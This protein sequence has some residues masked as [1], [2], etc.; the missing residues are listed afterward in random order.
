MTPG[1]AGGINNHLQIMEEFM[2]RRKKI[3]LTG[4]FSILLVFTIMLAGCPDGPGDEKVVQRTGI[5]LFTEHP[6]SIDY[7]DENIRPLKVTA[8]VLDKPDM[9]E[10]GN[11]IE[12]DLDYQW[13]IVNEFTN[14]GGT[15]IEG[16]TERT[17]IPQL[18]QLNNN[19]GFFYVRVSN[20]ATTGAIRFS[21]PARIR[22]NQTLTTPSATMVISNTERQY[23]RGFG[24]MSNAF[25]IGGDTGDVPRYME[26]E[27]IHTMFNPEHPDYMGFKVLR[28]CLFP[29]TLQEVLSGEYGT[30]EM[31]TSNADYVWFARQVSNYGGYVVAAPWTPS[32]FSWKANN[33]NLGIGGSILNAAFRPYAEYLRAFAQD[34]ANFGAPIYAVSIQNEPTYAA[35]YDG[36]LWSETQQRDFMRDHGS[37]IT[38]MNAS[39][40]QGSGAFGGGVRGAGG[41]VTGS[42][43]PGGQ[44]RVRL[45]GGSPHNRVAW[46]DAALND[47]ASRVQLEIAAYHTYGDWNMRYANALGTAAAGSP[48]VPPALPRETWMMEKN[49]NSG[50]VG[51]QRQDSTWP[52][53]W[54]PVNEW[55]HVI[56][57]NDTSVYCWWYAKRFYSFIGDATFGTEN[58]A[59]LPRGHAMAHFALYL[60]DTVRLETSS[61]G[62]FNTTVVN[63]WNQS[64]SGFQTTAGIRAVAGMRTSS[65]AGYAQEKLKNKEDLVT[66]VLTDSRVTGADNTIKVDL[67][68]G[69]NA[70]SAHGIFSTDDRYREPVLVTLNTDGRSAIVTLPAH[71]MISLAF[72]GFW[73]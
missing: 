3:L 12:I 54:L 17:F 67:P 41:G 13:F 64:A 6:T 36:M 42:N 40:V 61:T 5:P 7:E 58:N 14:T 44:Q 2:L 11:L 16:A 10:L 46:N 62:T 66:L 37:V 73:D 35:N 72:N 69:F 59:V 18:T 71:S 70:T 4:I 30:P 27:D 52:L 57:H 19:V 53:I 43:L 48:V 20:P 39:G 31:H 9:G 25:W 56:A 1:F 63:R 26:R 15:A 28:I 47:S 24:G 8:K 23:I 49:V 34:M 29:A 32:N 65:P 50:D 33:S 22:V 55:H 21:N 45:M 51:G 68:E 60:T 38:G